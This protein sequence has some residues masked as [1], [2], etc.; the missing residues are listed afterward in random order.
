[1][2]KTRQKTAEEKKKEE[3]DYLQWLSGQTEHLK[4]EHVE[5][6]LKPLKEFWTNP[7]LDEGEKFLRDYVLKKK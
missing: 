4:D 1:M 6:D 2:F 5:N 3:E 7:K